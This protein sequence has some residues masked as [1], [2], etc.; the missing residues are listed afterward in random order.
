MGAIAASYLVVAA[1][2]IAWYRRAYT[3]LAF[4]RPWDHM[5]ALLGAG[6]TITLAAL[7]AMGVQRVVTLIV[8]AHCTSADV[9]YFGVAFGLAF[10]LLMLS[11]MLSQA[12]LPI[13]ARGMTDAAPQVA[14]AQF[15]SLLKIAVLLIT[16][17]V[18][19][20]SFH[21]RAIVT[22]CYGQ[23]YAPAAPGLAVLV[24]ASVCLVVANTVRTYLFAADRQRLWLILLGISSAVVLLGAGYA[25]PRH[26][27]MGG[28]V[29]I[30]AGNAVLLVMAGVVALRVTSMFTRISPRH[31][32][33]LGLRYVIAVVAAV[34][35]FVILRGVHFV[36]SCV[37][38]GVIYA[39]ACWLL[40]LLNRDT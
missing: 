28:C 24:A 19:V 12:S 11:N 13:L 30:L 40:G 26:G 25:V 20:V 27:I 3:R 15:R 34:A 4:G 1:A 35:L 32:L 16:P 7:L 17:V 14:D 21:S 5:R 36:V 33:R 31:L 2:A 6:W 8:A 9:G 23:A 18:L 29:A 10:N 22:L 38:A 37:A 39:A